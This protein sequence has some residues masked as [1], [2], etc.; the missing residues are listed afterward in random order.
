MSVVDLEIASLAAGGDGVGRDANGRVTFVPR[1]APGDRVRVKLVAEKSSFAR[2]ELLEVVEPSPLR[3]EPACAAFARGCGGCQ[4]LHVTRAAQLDAKQVI[5]TS[6][7]RKWGGA[8]VERI[9]DPG[10]ELRWRR[11]ARFHSRNGQLGLYAARTRTVVPLSHCPQL[12]PA[13]EAV[14]SLFTQPGER[15]AIGRAPE[16]EVPH[17]K[18]GHGAG[19][20][21]QTPGGI[22]LPDGEV[23]LVVGARGDVAVGLDRPWNQAASLV[24]QRGIVGVQVKSGGSFGDP[25]VEIEPGLWGGPW[26]FAQASAGGNAALVDL[27]RTALGPGPGVVLELYAGAGNFT[28]AFAADGWTVYPSDVAAPSR[29][30]TNFIV[31][32]AEHVVAGFAACDAIVLDPPREGAAAAIAGMVKCAPTT[33]VYVSCDPNTLARDVEKLVEAGYRVDRVWPIDLMPQTAH[34]EVVVRLV[35]SLLTPHQ[36]AET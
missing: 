19:M 26:D 12:D 8:I 22:Q 4:W 30:I 1:S 7:L 2:G 29:A 18:P 15:S 27:V 34:V 16:S 36:T 32:T 31:G 24:G 11:R 10:P 33:I 13:L 9:A 21:R 6:A 5:V 28:R 17:R 25:I 14:L 35:K 3:L 23:A 20:Q